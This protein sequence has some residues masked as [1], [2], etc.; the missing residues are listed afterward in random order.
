MPVEPSKCNC[1]RSIKLDI[2]EIDVLVMFASS[3]K[4]NIFNDLSED[5]MAITPSSSI[6]SHRVKFKYYTLEIVAD[7]H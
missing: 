2:V 5:V 3:H 6:F 7:S 4:N 1:S